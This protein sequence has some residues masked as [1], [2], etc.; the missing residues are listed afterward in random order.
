MGTEVTLAKQQ[1]TCEVYPKQTSQDSFRVKEDMPG[2]GLS[3]SWYH[4]GTLAD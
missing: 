4:G 1:C 3:L 2:Q